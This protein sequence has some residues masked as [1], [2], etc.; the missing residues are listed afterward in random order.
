MQDIAVVVGL[1]TACTAIGF[2][3]CLLLPKPRFRA[4]FVIAPPIGFGLFAIAGTVLYLWGVRPW[5]AMVTMAAAGLVLGTA[6]LWRSQRLRLTPPSRSTMAFGAGTV[7]VILICLLPG[8][9]GGPQFRIFQANVYDQLTYL[10]GAVTFRSLDYASM[11]AEAARAAPDP[12]VAKSAWHL[13]HRGAVSIVQAAVAAISRH[14]LIDSGYPFMVA[15]QVN[16]LFA[17]LFVLINVF[18]AGYRLSF[19]LASALTLGFFQ[20][21]VFDIDAWSELS[22]QPI[23]LLLLAFT[24]LAFDDRGFA[25]GGFSGIARLAGIF[26]ALLGAVLYLYPEALSIYGIAATTGAVMAIGRRQRRGTALFGLAGLALGACAAVLLCLLFWNGTLQFMFRQ[27]GQ[28]AIEPNDWWQYFSRYLFGSEQNYLAILTNPASSDGQVAAAWFSL[29]VESV[30]AAL[31]LHLLLP[32]ASWPFGLAV[33]WK[34]VLYGFLAVLI[35]A[36]AGGV[37]R[38]W[39][40]DSAGNAARMTG[41]CIGGCIVPFIILSTG[42]FWA[43]GKGLSMAAPLLFLLLTTPLLAKPDGANIARV[44]RLASLAFVLAHLALGL[45]RP[46]LVTEFA[47]AQLPGLPTAAAQVSDQKAG[48]DWNYQRWAAEIRKCNGVI[49]EI[50]SPFMHQLVRRVASDLGVPWA[51]AGLIWPDRT[52]QPY[53]PPGWENFACVVSTSVATAKPGQTLIGVSKDRSIFDYLEGRLA[54]LEIGTKFVP[55]V[56]SRGAYDL[57]TYQDGTVRWTSQVAQFEA[58]NN[59][60]APSRSLRLELWPM[61]LSGDALEITVNGDTVYRGGI[62]SDALT[63]SLDKYSAQDRL[64]IE[65]FAAAVTHYPNDPRTLGVAIKQLRLGKQVD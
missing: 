25:A 40:A 49:I 30:M 64:T 1:L 24:V 11:T 32:T 9:T 56:S 57:E 33:V 22:A 31:G 18:S 6:S 58:P 65:L 59:P 13:E 5:I 54:D 38:I 55:G 3:L 37:A 4:R 62:P 17:A 63:L 48:L 39:R 43:A 12:I 53:F 60:A 47:G 8:W 44:G 21:Y 41:A 10:G 42:H 15:M 16:I 7:A 51:S 20:Q 14:D 34:I 29:P 45:L 23:Y 61:P 2:P 52:R 27:F 35:K 26:A 36:A 28:V 46:I 19:F 50:D